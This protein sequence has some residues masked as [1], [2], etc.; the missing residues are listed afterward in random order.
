MSGSEHRDELVE[1][2]CEW[3]HEENIAG[4]THEVPF[5]TVA[6]VDFV[7]QIDREGHVH[8]VGP[9]CLHCL[10]GDVEHENF[11]RSSGYLPFTLN[12]Q[13][14]EGENAENNLHPDGEFVE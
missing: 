1:E 14:R 8:G 7:V 3:H 4:E 12:E 5:A 13:T 11:E 2:E 6:F 9:E 10:F